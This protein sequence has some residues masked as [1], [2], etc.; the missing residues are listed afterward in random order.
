MAWATDGAVDLPGA[1][2]TG[3][4]EGFANTAAM[5]TLTSPA[6]AAVLAYPGSDSSAG[7]WFIP[8]FDELALVYDSTLHS[9]GGFMNSDSSYYWTSYNDSA[10]SGTNAQAWLHV[11]DTNSGQGNDV[12]PIGGTDLR[13]NTYY[14]RPIRA[15]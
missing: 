5:A 11:F 2:G 15:F 1:S 9:T 7:Q 12:I 10:H 6:A 4:G 3:I 13:T 14:V 8:S